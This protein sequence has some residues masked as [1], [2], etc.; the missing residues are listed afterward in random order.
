MSKLKHPKKRGQTR[1]IRATAKRPDRGARR[2]PEGQRALRAAIVTTKG[3]VLGGRRYRREADDILLVKERRR[4][5][6]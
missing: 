2:A 3:Q 1:R 4:R 6:Q 5:R